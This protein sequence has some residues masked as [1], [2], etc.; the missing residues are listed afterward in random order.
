MKQLFTVFNFV[1][2]LLLAGLCVVQWRSNR[3]LNQS[4][5][6]LLKER[7]AQR[8]QLEEQSKNLAGL[9]ADLDG[10]R[11]RVVESTDRAKAAETRAD[12]QE[13]TARELETE[14]DQLR[15][16]LTNWVEAVTARDERLRD[17][18]ARLEEMAAARHAA[19]V[20]FNELAERYNQLATNPPAGKKE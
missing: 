13:R 5:T 15:V 20:K 17:F 18:A 14:R 6:A 7:E 19:V 12:L 9:R 10:F 4:I 11:G 2:V 8:A 16:S 1:G 3:T